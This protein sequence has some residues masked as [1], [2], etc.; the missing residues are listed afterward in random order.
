MRGR[1]AGGAFQV[2]SNSPIVF[3][4]GMLKL[5]PQKVGE[6]GSE[7]TSGG[8]NDLAILNAPE[9][10]LRAARCSCPIPSDGTERSGCEEPTRATRLAT[11]LAT[12]LAVNSQ[13]PIRLVH[14]P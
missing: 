12:Q 8:A 13:L 6:R 7:K 9:T 3:F 5:S 4:P 14:S 2:R 11:Q 1:W 10:H